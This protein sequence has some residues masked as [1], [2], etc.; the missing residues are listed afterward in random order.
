[1]YFFIILIS[2]SFCADYRVHFICLCTWQSRTY[3]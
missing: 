2:V 3:W 1:M